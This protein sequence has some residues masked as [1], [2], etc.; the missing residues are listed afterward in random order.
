VATW[1][2]RGQYPTGDVVEELATEPEAQAAI[3]RHQ[4]Q[5]VP[6]AV[7]SPAPPE[8]TAPT[9]CSFCGKE[10]AAVGGLVAGPPE[11]NVAICDQCV[12]LCAEILSGRR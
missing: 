10:R 8:A 3:R 6:V 11:A 9:R 1:T 4:A 2:V 5:G 7:R 12:A